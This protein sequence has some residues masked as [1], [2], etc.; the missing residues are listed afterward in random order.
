MIYQSSV[1]DIDQ[2]LNQGTLN[3][4]NFHS[5]SIKLEISVTE[6]PVTLYILNMSS[7]WVVSRECALV[8]EKH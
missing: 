6:F 5:K 1:D 4:S 8:L 3:L 2:S 7:V